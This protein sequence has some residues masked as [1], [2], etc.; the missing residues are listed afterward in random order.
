VGAAR[1]AALDVF[2]P[3]ALGGAAAGVGVG[4]VVAA[5]VGFGLVVV[6]GFAPFALEVVGLVVDD[7]TAAAAAGVAAGAVLDCFGLDLVCF[8]LDFAMVVDVSLFV[9]VVD[10]LIS[11]GVVV[12][13]LALSLLVL[14]ELLLLVVVLLLLV[15]LLVFVGLPHV[16]AGAWTDDDPPGTNALAPEFNFLLSFT[17][18]CYYYFTVSFNITVT[19][20]VT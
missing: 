15:L 7:C 4:V 11:D 3:H 10:G 6:V 19:Y 18:L 20:S 2:L 9:V 16:D 13:V 17:M 5:G 12:L 8:D 14:F 1:M